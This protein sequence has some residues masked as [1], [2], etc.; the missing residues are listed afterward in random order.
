MDMNELRDMPVKKP[1]FKKTILETFYTM[2]RKGDLFKHFGN[3]VEAT[4]VHHSKLSLSLKGKD[5]IYT[6]FSEEHDLDIL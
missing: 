1:V 2:A 4:Y 6:L 5:T 3:I